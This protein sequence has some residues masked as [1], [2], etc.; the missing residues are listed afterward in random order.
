MRTVLKKFVSRS[1][2]SWLEIITGGNKTISHSEIIAVNKIRLSS[3]CLIQP[4]IEGATTALTKTK[5]RWA[6]VEILTDTYRIKGT[7]FIPLPGEAAH[8]SLVF[9]LRSNSIPTNYR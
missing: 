6:E 4:S 1:N 7:L 5:G 9:R 3:G 2:H 8:H